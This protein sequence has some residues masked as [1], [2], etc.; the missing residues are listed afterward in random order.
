M[1]TTTT[2]RVNST[3]LSD[4]LVDDKDLRRRGVE[5][6]M[7]HKAHDRA[8]G[9]FHNRKCRSSCT[10]CNPRSARGAP[11]VTKR[12]SAAAELEARDSGSSSDDYGEWDD[13]Y[14]DRRVTSS[15]AH[16]CSDECEHIMGAQ[17][18]VRSL[19]KRKGTYIG[20]IQWV[21]R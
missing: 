5:L 18:I 6:E 7:A 13:A 2:Q 14:Y 16:R 20:F 8:R 10:L 12:D 15:V 11:T 17:V 4:T 9:K 19:R 1:S 21:L 3:V